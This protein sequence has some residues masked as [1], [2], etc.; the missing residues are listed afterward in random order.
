MTKAVHWRRSGYCAT[1]GCVEVAR[2]AGSTGPVI[3]IRDG[4]LP[5]AGAL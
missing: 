3:A 1:N 4:T 5:G 2:L